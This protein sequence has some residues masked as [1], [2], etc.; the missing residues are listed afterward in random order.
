MYSK[1]YIKSIIKPISKNWSEAWFNNYYKIIEYFSKHDTCDN[2][3]NF[4]HVIPVHVSVDENSTTFKRRAQAIAYHDEK[5]NIIDNVV[6]LPIKMHVIAHYCLAKATMNKKD[7][8]SFM[9]LH[10]D[11]TRDFYSMTMHDVEE[12]SNL[13]HESGFPNSSEHYMTIDEMKRQQ[14]EYRHEYSK[15]IRENQKKYLKNLKNNNKID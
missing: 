6:K 10:G 13:V 12:L 11:F 9:I 1:E 14:Q 3:Y 2:K 7:I 15:K 8:N 4:H 5:Y